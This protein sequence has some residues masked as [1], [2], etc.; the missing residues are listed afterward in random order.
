MAFAPSNNMTSPFG[1][2]VMPERMRLTRWEGEGEREGRR[3]E[4]RGSLEVVRAQV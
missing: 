1:S 4:G 3:K 2:A